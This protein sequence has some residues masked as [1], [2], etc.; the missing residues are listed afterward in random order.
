MPA[1]WRVGAVLPLSGAEAEFGAHAKNGVELAIAQANEHGGASGH[2]VEIVYRDT[3]GEAADA[4]EAVRDLVEREHVVAIVGE[5]AAS[6]SKAGGLVAN[7]LGVPM[8]TP[9]TTLADLGKIGPFVFRACVTD[10]A[11]GRAAARFVVEKLGK[12]RIAL[13]YPLDGAAAKV[14]ADRFREE[15]KRLGG[16][17]VSDQAFLSMDTDYTP[18][19]K[20]AQGAGAEVYYAP[21]FANQMVPL[22]K[23]AS[24]LGV[25]G[26]ALVGA[27]G[28]D[29]PA[30][31]REAG[32]A[33]EGATF[34]TQYALDPPWA[35]AEALGSAYRARFADAPSP[36]AALSYD[37]ARLVVD[38]I[39]RAKSP[40]PAAIRDALA[41]T[42]GFAGATGTTSFGAGTDPTKPVSVVKVEGGVA[43][44]FAEIR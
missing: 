29:D 8:I 35:A 31:L 11:E 44:F 40:V 13:V 14:K 34:T 33:L 1:V 43:R 16:E 26:D 39:A 24:A 9:T 36:I 38:A 41:S 27:D 18:Y 19:L 22:A 4:A 17:V 6:R 30:R 5:V 15:A 2:P 20:A 10:E 25:R 21:T 32:D 12:K 37:A 3:H 7:R 42:S 23:Q 28:W